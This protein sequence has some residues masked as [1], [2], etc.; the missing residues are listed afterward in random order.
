MY[1]VISTSDIRLESLFNECFPKKLEKNPNPTTA[2]VFFLLLEATK[3]KYLS[4]ALLSIP[5]YISNTQMTL[6]LCVVEIKP[7]LSSHLY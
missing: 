4:L 1:V 6:I 7:I 2:F 5:A 3:Q